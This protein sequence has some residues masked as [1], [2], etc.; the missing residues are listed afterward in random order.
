MEKFQLAL[1]L[2]IAGIGSASGLLYQDNKLY[3]ISDNSNYLYEYKISEE[4][5][6]KIAL[7]E[8]PQ[9]NIPKKEKPDFVFF[10]VLLFFSAAVFL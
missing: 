3:I 4:T 7:T 1:L 6:N 10:R 9:E 8:N 2:K 5:L